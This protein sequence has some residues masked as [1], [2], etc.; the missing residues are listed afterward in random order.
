MFTSKMAIKTV[1]VLACCKALQHCA[2]CV[3][4]SQ[5]SKSVSQIRNAEQPQ[6]Q[7]LKAR[8]EIKNKNLT[9]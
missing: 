8:N 4:P 5:Q 7:F 1:C 3:L 9:A 2:A 6:I